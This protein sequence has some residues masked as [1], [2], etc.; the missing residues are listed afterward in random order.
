MKHLGAGRLGWLP[1]SLIL[2]A[3]SAFA[4]PI[5]GTFGISGPGVLVFNNSGADF[6]QFCTNA[7]ATGSGCSGAATATGDFGVSGPGTLSFNVLTNTSVGTVINTTDASNRAIPNSVFAFFP[8]GVASTLNNYLTVTGQG[9]WNFQANMLAL[10]SCANG[11]TSSQQCVGPFQLNQ[12]GANVNVFMDVLGTLINTTD[13]SK[14]NLNVSF[15]AT[16]NN[17]TI[18][19]VEA[20]ATSAAGAFNPSWAATVSATAASTVPEPSTFTML[21]AGGCLLGL[22]QVRRRRRA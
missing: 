7:N 18:G 9:T 4:S 5:V 20:A 1:A 13:N 12:N 16:Y 11:N 10:A 15:S 17:T 21:I 14:S 22:S 19:A 6:L 8:V 2:I 3:G